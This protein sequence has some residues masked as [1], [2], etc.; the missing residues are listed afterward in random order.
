M[1]TGLVSDIRVMG[2][3]CSGSRDSDLFDLIKGYK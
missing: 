3:G 1:P 2:V